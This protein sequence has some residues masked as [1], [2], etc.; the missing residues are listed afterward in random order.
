[1][2]MPVREKR[3]G[4]GSCIGNGGRG[5]I[6]CQQW[7]R[8][9]DF[10]RFL[11]F[12]NCGARSFTRSSPPH[13]TR[14]H[15]QAFEG[16]TL[17]MAIQVRERRRGGGSCIGNGGRGAICCQQWPRQHDF[18]RFWFF[19]NCGARSFTRSSPPHT[20]HEHAQAFEEHKLKMA[21]P[22]REMRRGGGLAL[23]MEVGA[24]F[25]VSSGPGNMVS[26]VVGFFK[27]WGPLIMHS[28]LT[29]TTH[30]HTQAFYGDKLKVAVPVREKRRGGG[31]ALQTEVGAPYAVSSGPGNM[32][33]AVV[34]FQT[35]GPAHHAL[36][37]HHPTQHMRTHRP[38]TGTS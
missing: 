15:T 12:S 10:C 22:V 19:S 4:G 38:S 6:C 5:A 32:V 33:S 11:F 35:V 17:K 34:G 9:H 26:A 8:Q 13:T 20:T 24:P 25:V 3:R 27:L 30:A 31:L 21:M 37:P 16:D 7:P 14:A 23:E 2:A 29:H 36:G 28:V 18:C 1:M